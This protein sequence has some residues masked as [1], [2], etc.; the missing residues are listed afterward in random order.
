MPVRP[1]NRQLYPGGSPT[2]RLWRD[3]V[4]WLRLR[5]GNRCEGSPTYPDCRAENG[6]PHPVTGSIVVLTAAHL[7]HDPA[8]NGP[9]DLR[10][11]CQRCH[12]TYDA[13]HRLKGAAL[14][15]AGEAKS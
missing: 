12:N 2:S 10:H 14:R 11:W 8:R 3:I 7:A 1:E 4:A 6:L 15:R 5:S 9:D 13:Q